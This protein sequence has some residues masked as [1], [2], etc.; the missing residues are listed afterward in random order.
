M[1]KSLAICSILGALVLFVWSALSWMVIPWHEK[2]MS[3]FTDDK[4]VSEAIRANIKGS[5]VY[6]SPADEARVASGPLVYAAIRQEGM[7]SLTKPLIISFLLDVVSALLV[8]WLLLQT[9][10]R[11]FI[12]RVGFVVIVALAVGVIARLP[13]WNWWGFPPAYTAVAVV[14]LVIGWFLAGLV[15]AKFARAQTSTA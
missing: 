1:T 14:D 7:T 9:N 8:T 3:G 10:A 12:S 5:G 15:I 6:F 4:A 13:D 2:T 11:S